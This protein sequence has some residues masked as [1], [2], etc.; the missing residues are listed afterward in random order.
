MRDIVSPLAGFASPF[1]RG[2]DPYAILGYRPPL[3][4]DY[5]NSKFRVSGST[6]TAPNVYTATRTGLATQL[7]ASGN[8]VWNA[9]NLLTYSEDFSNAAWVKTS[10]NI[11]A[12][13]II[14]PDGTTTAELIESSG[15]G[16]GFSSV[17]TQLLTVFPAKH[18]FSCF[19]KA[20][21]SSWVALRQSA[22]GLGVTY[23]YFNLS[24][25]AL[26]TNSNDASRITD[27]GNGWYLCEIDVT[28]SS[29]DT[30]GR[31][32]IFPL[33]EEGNFSYPLDGSVSVY[34][35]GAHLYRSDF[36]GMAPVPLT[37]RVAGSTTYVPTTSAAVYLP[38]E[39]A[40]TYVSGSLVGPYYQKESDARTNLVTYSVPNSINWTESPATIT[41]ASLVVAPDGSSDPVK[42]SNAAVDDEQQILFDPIASG[43]GIYTIYA[44]FKDSGEGV[45]PQI[46][47]LNE[48]TGVFFANFNLTTGALGNTGGTGFVDAGMVEYQ[49]GWYL[50][51]VAGE[52]AS[53]SSGLAIALSKN[54]DSDGEA[55]VDPNMTYL[56]DG[57][58]FYMWGAQAEQSSVPTSYIPTSGSTVTRSADSPLT[59]AGADVP[60]PT[61]TVIG[62]N[63]DDDFSSYA[64]QAAAETAGY[65]FT[66]CTF[67]AANDQV[68][69]SGV[70][71][72]FRFDTAYTSDDTAGRVYKAT[73]TVSN[74]VSGSLS[75][76]DA[77]STVATVPTSNGTHEFIFVKSA[78]SNNV[79]VVTADFTGSL[80]NISVKE[81]N[82]L[83]LSFQMEGLMTY[84]D[85]DVPA[86][87]SGGLGEVVFF[88]QKIDA[89]NYIEAVLQTHIGTGAATFIQEANGSRDRVLTDGS[90]YSPGIN[91]PFNIASRHGSTFI[92]GAGDGTA[93]T[94]DT[95]PTALPDLSATTFNLAPTF[96]GFI[97]E[98]RVWADDLG[99]SGIAEAST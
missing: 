5:E 56:G 41:S 69:F 45:H 83:A 12:N 59:I 90:F 97:K 20:G 57:S 4:L 62:T 19:L 99:D 21:S 28:I 30:V 6:S 65:A 95:T 1:G 98:F 72:N 33:D 46:R 96:N 25:G 52:Y 48:G 64:D 60:W 38:R 89:S 17:E 16:T 77:F 22:F 37:R 94:A 85:N 34:A 63:L 44:F 43:A 91:V 66:G 49:D 82:P 54:P 80:D 8:L 58:G 10:A 9:H 79:R 29:S 92:N 3:V 67:D 11:G 93:L 2:A 68:D 13:A 15:G 47:P 24:T 51:Y 31:F 88:H 87:V 53:A 39:E 75:F 35:W 32:A 27:F 73:V 40:Y 26:G 81:I 23:S 86:D 55:F 61:P 50:C 78:V 36:G 42:I 74:Y 76:Q 7:D 14:A 18:T 84:A 71:A 70:S